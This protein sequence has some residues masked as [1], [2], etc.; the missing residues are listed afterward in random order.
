MFGRIVAGDWLDVL[1]SWCCFSCDCFNPVL[2]VVPIEGLRGCN[3]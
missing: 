2:V 1:Q 3:K